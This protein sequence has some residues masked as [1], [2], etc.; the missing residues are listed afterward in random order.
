MI[1]IEAKREMAPMC[2]A[3][4]S[5]IRLASVQRNSRKWRRQATGR[6]YRIFFAQ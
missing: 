2:K 3:V 4:R 6:N 1:I 5:F